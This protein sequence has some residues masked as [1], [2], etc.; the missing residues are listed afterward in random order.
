MV[1]HQ[2]GVVTVTSV[3]FVTFGHGNLPVT[4]SVTF[5]PIG[6]SHGGPNLVV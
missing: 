4:F 3:T 2:L 5:P 6:G 1:S